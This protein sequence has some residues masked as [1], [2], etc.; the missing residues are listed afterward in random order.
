MS[1]V[2]MFK[3]VVLYEHHCRKPEPP[4]YLTKNELLECCGSLTR[5][6]I[7]NQHGKRR[8]GGE[9]EAI[10]WPRLVHRAAERRP[11][12]SL[13]ANHHDAPHKARAPAL[14]RVTL[15]I[16]NTPPTDYMNAIEHTIT[17][18]LSRQPLCRNSL[19][20][21]LGC[22]HPRTRRTRSR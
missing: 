5:T 17:H 9:T 4:R 21:R 12:A 1:A 2:Q 6:Q 15:I 11:L 3:F 22:S 8:G 19:S 13:V 16:E 14:L 10:M 7:K 18:P 20:L